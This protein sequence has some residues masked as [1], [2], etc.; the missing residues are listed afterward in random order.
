MSGRTFRNNH[1]LFDVYLGE[2]TMPTV[3]SWNAMQLPGWA[4]VGWNTSPDPNNLGEWFDQDTIVQGRRMVYAHWVQGISFHPGAAPAHTISTQNRER[5]FDFGLLSTRLD[6]HP[7]GMPPNPVWPGRRFREWNTR[8][9]GLGVPYSGNTLITQSREL[10]AVWDVPVM[11]HSIDG[12]FFAD[13]QGNTSDRLVQAVAGTPLGGQAPTPPTRNN[14]SFDSWNES[15]DGTGTTHRPHGLSEVSIYG[16]D[17]GSVLELF[18]QWAGRITFD[19]NGGVYRGSNAD[20]AP[21][22]VLENR[23]VG[24]MPG[25]NLPE[26]EATQQHYAFLGWTFEDANGNVIPFTDSTEMSAQVIG[27]HIT[28]TAQWV[29]IRYTIDGGLPMPYTPSVSPFMLGN[30]IAVAPRYG[31]A[32]VNWDIEENGV[33]NTSVGTTVTGNRIGNY[34]TAGPI[35][36]R[37]NLVVTANFITGPAPATRTVT[38]INKVNDVIQTSWTY[39]GLFAVGEL[40]AISG[41]VAESFTYNRVYGIAPSERFEIFDNPASIDSDINESHFTRIIADQ[42]QLVSPISRASVERPM[43]FFRMPDGDVVITFEWTYLEDNNPPIVPP[44]ITNPPPL[45]PP[46]NVPPPIDPP[47]SVP[48][49]IDPPTNVPPPIDPPTNVPPPIDP[50]TNVPP[51]IDPPTNVPPPIDPPTNVPPTIEPPVIGQ[52][53]IN[54]PASTDSTPDRSSPSTNPSSNTRPRTSP[55]LSIAEEINDSFYYDIITENDIVEVV[56]EE[57]R[58]ELVPIF[59][60]FNQPVEVI[61]VIYIATEVPMVES[62]ENLILPVPVAVSGRVNPQTGDG[63][64]IVGLAVSGIGLISSA[65]LVFWLRKRRNI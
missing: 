7:Q 15:Q 47:T 6:E 5:V 21:I 40:V 39:S 63:Y 65:F 11:F 8:A 41:R 35:T 22:Y 36:A 28:V 56:E 59:E 61:E 44:P 55:T 26:L 32:L 18:A 20:P 10:H 43:Y 9:D 23:T 31:F 50:P 19:L 58:E 24:T 37:S 45:Y 53:D 2:R 25:I 46:A 33:S 62:Q 12:Q 42:S 52:P 60:N 29:Q 49:P 14:W 1:S 51:P 64:N 34:Y 27:G 48:P 38:I 17:N 57:V 16:N 4:F 13:S 30:T 3:Q 54:R